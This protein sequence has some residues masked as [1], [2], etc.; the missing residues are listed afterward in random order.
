MRTRTSQASF[1]PA[2]GH[3]DTHEIS[4]CGRLVRSLASGNVLRRRKGRVLVYSEEGGGKLWRWL[5]TE[6][7]LPPHPPPPTSRPPGHPGRPGPPEQPEEAGQLTLA[8]AVGSILNM[9]LT[10]LALAILMAVTLSV[11]CFVAIRSRPYPHVIPLASMPRL[12]LIMLYHRVMNTVKETAGWTT[13][14]YAGWIDEDR[15]WPS[16]L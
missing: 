13:P 14:R 10:L 1:I 5:H 3:E 2:F 7:L 15:R 4:A 11:V 9:L 12:V 16:D 8:A 6:S